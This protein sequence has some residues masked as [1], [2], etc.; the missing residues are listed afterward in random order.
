MNIDT[1][2]AYCGQGHSPDHACLRV[3]YLAIATVRSRALGRRGGVALIRSPGVASSTALSGRGDE[4]LSHP[5]PSAARGSCG[6]L[7]QEP[8]HCLS[9]GPSTFLPRVERLEPTGLAASTRQSLP[10]VDVLSFEAV[11]RPASGPWELEGN[12]NR[13]GRLAES[14]AKRTSRPRGHIEGPSFR[15]KPGVGLRYGPGSPPSLLPQALAGRVRGRGVRPEGKLVPRTAPEPTKHFRTLNKNPKRR[16]LFST[17]DL[18][19]DE[20]TR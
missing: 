10:S 9:S 15:S 1:S 17:L 8:S 2:N 6:T 16:T 12:R 20:T 19:S 14:L 5:L 18:R 7:A 11:S 13:I 3:G 4:W